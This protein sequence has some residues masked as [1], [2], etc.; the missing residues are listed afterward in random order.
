M[1]CGILVACFYV[2]Q[3]EVRMHQLVVRAQFFSL[4]ALL[5]RPLVLLQPAQRHAQRHAGI[6]VVLVHCKYRLK[7]G[8]SLPVL[9]LAE[10]ERGVTK[11]FLKLIHRNLPIE[12]VNGTGAVRQVLDQSLLC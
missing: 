8:S 2:K 11:L 1:L 4:V 3:G 9:A 10:G 7:A 5:N 6:E 12:Q